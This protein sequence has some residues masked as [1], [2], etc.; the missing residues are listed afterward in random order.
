[1]IDIV[2][3]S[4]RGQIVI[5]QRG[6]EHFGLQAGS[7]LVLIDRGD[8]LVLKKEEA[9]A[10]LEEEKEQA[11]WFALSAESLKEVWDNEQDDKIWKEYL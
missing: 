6:R 2:H 1:M 5:P 4:S 9:L 11:G 10:A 8:S 3:V 7:K